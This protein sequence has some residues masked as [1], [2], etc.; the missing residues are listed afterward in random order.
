MP[1]LNLDTDHD[2]IAERVNEPDTLFVACNP[3]PEILRKLSVLVQN[4]YPHSPRPV[5]PS[6][7]TWSKDGWRELPAP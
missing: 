3:T 7:L 5:S 6:L 2:R 1:A 4:T